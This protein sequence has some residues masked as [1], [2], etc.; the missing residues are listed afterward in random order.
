V[1]TD[2]VFLLPVLQVFHTFT[3]IIPF[4]GLKFQFSGDKLKN[5]IKFVKKYRNISLL[6][7]MSVKFYQEFTRIVMSSGN[8]TESICTFTLHTTM[9]NLNLQFV[10]RKMLRYKP[11]HHI[12]TKTLGEPVSFCV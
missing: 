11:T 10:A 3:F 1:S 9:K 12:L 4:R 5:M 7:Q 6:I 2:F 8:I